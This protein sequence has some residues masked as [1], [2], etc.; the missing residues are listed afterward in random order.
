MK[1]WIRRNHEAKPWPSFTVCRV[2][3]TD[4]RLQ[5]FLGAVWSS[6]EPKARGTTQR[7]CLPKIIKEM[8]WQRQRV[9]IHCVGEPPSGPSS[10]HLLHERTDAACAATASTQ[11]VR[12]SSCFSHT[13]VIVN[14]IFIYLLIPHNL[15]LPLFCCTGTIGG[16]ACRLSQLAPFVCSWWIFIHLCFRWAFVSCSFCFLP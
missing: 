14:F 13:S 5:L 4:R 9:H 11:T 12:T 16:I 10:I 7:S 15:L 1:Q 2:Q 8:Q 3:G 6:V